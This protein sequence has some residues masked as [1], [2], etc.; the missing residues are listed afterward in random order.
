M[1]LSPIGRVRGTE[2]SATKTELEVKPPFAIGA[3][4]RFGDDDYRGRQEKETRGLEEEGGATDD[5]CS[6][7]PE[8]PAMK[9]DIFA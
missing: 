1:E 5:L 6:Q 8:E 9:V 7:K 3:M 2:P 4:E